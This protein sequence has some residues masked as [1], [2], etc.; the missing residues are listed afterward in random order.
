MTANEI[1]RVGMRKFE[2]YIGGI[3]G[4][5][6]RFTTTRE[7]QIR[8][9]DYY[10]DGPNIKNIELELK[11][12]SKYTG[13]LFL[14]VWADAM[15]NPPQPGWLMTINPEILGCLFLDINRLYLMNFR[16]LKG[17]YFGSGRF[18]T[19]KRVKVS[20]HNTRKYTIG[21]IITIREVSASV[22]IVA[23]DLAAPLANQANLESLIHDIR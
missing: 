10:I 21:H 23:V 11:T 13:N 12:E 17:W 9:I 7:E 22:D 6:Y 4:W 1:E 19:A 16:D 2:D 14:E 3:G 8:G 20:A 18:V 5:D 15:A